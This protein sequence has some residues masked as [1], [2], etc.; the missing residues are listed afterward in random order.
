MS[1]RE[2]LG[3]RNNMEPFLNLWKICSTTCGKPRA[4]AGGYDALCSV[5]LE[6]NRALRAAGAAQ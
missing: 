3:K 5:K 4:D 2:V 6:T 1:I